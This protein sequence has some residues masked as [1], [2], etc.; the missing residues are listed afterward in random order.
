[1]WAATYIDYYGYTNGKTETA[2]LNLED[3]TFTRHTV[4][5][6][7]HD[8]FCPGISMLGDGDIVVTGGSDSEKTSIYTVAN[9]WQGA[10]DMNIPRGYHSSC[11]LGSG[12]VHLLYPSY[13]QYIHPDHFAIHLT[14]NCAIN[15]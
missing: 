9:G 13:F 4:T 3:M 8:M 6:N 5:D 15:I 11:T 1:M 7:Q 14:R 2:I 10:Q 12:E